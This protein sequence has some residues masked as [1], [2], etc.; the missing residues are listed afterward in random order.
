MAITH[1]QTKPGPLAAT[2]ATSL[3]VTLDAAPAANN[4]LF[5]VV[6]V[7]QSNITIDIPTGWT[8]LDT[9]G[10]ST[11]TAAM[12]YR[13]ANGTEQST[14]FSWSPAYEATAIVSE[15]SGLD[16]VSPLDRVSRSDVASASTSAP[17]QL[18][19]TSTPGLAVSALAGYYGAT[20]P[21]LSI[22]SGFTVR[23]FLTITASYDP[24]AAVADVEYTTAAAIA[25]TWTSS[26]STPLW[27]ILALFKA[28]SGG[29]GHAVAAANATVAS[30]VSGVSVGQAHQV[31]ADAQTCGASISGVA[32]S[33]SS[34]VMVGAADMQAAATLS[35]VAISG[36]TVVTHRVSA[37][38]LLI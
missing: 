22:D 20:K 35:G 15:Y 2:N 4:L 16:S 25:P 14:T 29:S 33:Q 28:A 34:T 18:T 38:N 13:V 19:P 9:D 12:F 27:S 30:S 11:Y 36:G 37:D 5:A 10:G 17:A 8:L 26:V 21:V 23:A 32:V 7:R 24:L 1:V 3:T 6:V 31:A